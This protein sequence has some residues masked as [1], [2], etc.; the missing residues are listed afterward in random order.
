[1]LECRAGKEQNHYRSHHMCDVGLVMDRLIEA[2][3][4]VNPKKLFMGMRETP[5]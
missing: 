2:G 5:Y 1:M 3:F 4:T